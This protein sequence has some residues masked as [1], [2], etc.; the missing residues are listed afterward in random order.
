MRSLLGAMRRGDDE[1]ELVPQP[2]LDGL[3]SLREEIGRAG[4]P[5]ALHVDGEPVPLPRGID[6]SV[7][8]IVQEGLTNALKHAHATRATSSCAT[9]PTSSSSR[10]GTTASAARRATAAGT[11]SSAFANASRSMVAR[12]RQE[13]QTKAASSSARLLLSSD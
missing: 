5:V 1:A 12:W 4:L 3:E 6:L 9:G 10:S 11:G 2:G 8:R 7:Y 13:R